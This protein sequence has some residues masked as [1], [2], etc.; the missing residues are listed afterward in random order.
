MLLISQAFVQS[1]DKY[2]ISLTA[3][4]SWGLVES[5]KKQGLHSVNNYLKVQSSDNQLVMKLV[6]I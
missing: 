1:Q 5:R 2:K 4:N 3:Q 6:W